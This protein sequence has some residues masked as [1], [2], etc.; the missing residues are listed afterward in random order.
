MAKIGRNEPC[1]CGSG[2]KFK[3]CCLSRQR[4]NA[5]PPT[6]A[7]DITLGGE[8]EKIRRAASAREIVVRPVGVFILF[9]SGAG[10]AW[11]LE[12]SEMDAV[13]VARDGAELSM[14][15]DEN[16]QTI[17]VNWSHSFAIEKNDFV[18]TSHR[19][20]GKHIFPQYPAQAI[21][22]ALKGIRKRI[23][24]TSPHILQSMKIP[25]DHYAAVTASDH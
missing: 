9:S 4:S 16:S 24:S 13:Q 23:S 18:V 22:N 17:E 3:K 20:G 10:D 11:L 7:G 5:T 8:V 12:A 21:K 15:I 14:E 6:R 1:W 2:K 25:E 19:D